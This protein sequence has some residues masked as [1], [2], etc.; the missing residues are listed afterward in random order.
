MTVRMDESE[1][2]MTDHL[3]SKP[4][5]YFWKDSDGNTL[6][7][8]KAKELRRRVKSYLSPG[9]KHSPRIKAMLSKAASVDFVLTPG[10]RDALLLESNL[11]K[12]HQPP[13]NVLLKDDETYQ[14]ICASVGDAFPQF[15]AVPRRQEGEKAAR[16]RY[17]GP[18]PH[19]NEINA[20]LDSIEANHDLRQKSFEARHGGSMSKQEY[21]E[22]FS[23][24]LE[25]SF[26]S[27]ATNSTLASMR[28]DYEEAG[29]LFD[30]AY[31]D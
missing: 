22:L 31:N 16:Y 9:A 28:S 3:P 11:I 17:F 30:S 13:Y 18:Y 14:Y 8:G 20:V 10:D 15:Y 2:V 25:E 27:G 4:G 1:P 6:Y 5:V 26:E 29:L 7:I 24:V 21:N 19:Y 23:R 12:H